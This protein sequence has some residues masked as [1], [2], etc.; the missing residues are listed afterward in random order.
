M[1]ECPHTT[2]DAYHSLSKAEEQ[3]ARVRRRTGERVA[4]YQC[5]GKPTHFHLGHPTAYS[6]VAKRGMAS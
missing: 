2:K 5:P 1:S 4:A 3:A 6:R